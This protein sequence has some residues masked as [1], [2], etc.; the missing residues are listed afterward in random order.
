MQ[1]LR[2]RTRLFSYDVNRS[3]QETTVCFREDATVTLLDSRHTAVKRLIDSDDVDSN[4]DLTD[5]VASPFQD[6]DEELF[7][8]FD[9]CD[10]QDIAQHES[11]DDDVS[12]VF[13]FL[14][15]YLYLHCSS[16][17][18]DGCVRELLYNNPLS[19]SNKNP[20]DSTQH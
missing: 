5:C 9:S 17:I 4:H 7:N 16:Y 19:R 10:V 15:R 2:H 14:R 3:D 18:V 20:L 12:D 13:D 11:T 6:N 1:R 8:V